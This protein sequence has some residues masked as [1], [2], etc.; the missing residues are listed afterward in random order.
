MA[1]AL[2]LLAREN[3]LQCGKFNGRILRWLD[4]PIGVRID[5]ALMQW[6]V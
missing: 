1:V 3:L 4:H 2:K 5:S 6:I